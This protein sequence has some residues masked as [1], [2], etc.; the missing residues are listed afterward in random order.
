MEERE[1]ER[2]RDVSRVIL[3]ISKKCV[4]FFLSLFSR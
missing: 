1:R 2:E 4:S 3:E